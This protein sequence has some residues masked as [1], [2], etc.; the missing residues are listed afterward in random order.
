[1]AK[2]QKKEIKVVMKFDVNGRSV[3]RMDRAW[4]LSQDLFR[5]GERPVHAKFVGWERID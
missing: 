3:L 1:M 5:E 4:S 2:D